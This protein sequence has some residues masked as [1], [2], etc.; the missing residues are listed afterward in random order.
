MVYS[1]WILFRMQKGGGMMAVATIKVGSG[2]GGNN[3]I[4]RMVAGMVQAGQEV[5]TLA[6]HRN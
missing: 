5:Q 3:K 6:Q 1:L 4:E 2:W